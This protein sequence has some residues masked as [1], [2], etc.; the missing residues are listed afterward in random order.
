MK[1]STTKQRL[2]Q[3][4]KE[5]NLRQVDILKRSE[6]YQNEFGVKLSKANLS[7]YLSGKSTPDKKKINLLA[8]TLQVSEAWLSGF[9]APKDIVIDKTD[10]DKAFQSDKIAL[11]IEYTDKKYNHKDRK[12]ILNI[13]E[14]F[15]KL[16]D[17]SKKSLSQYSDI[18]LEATY[19]SDE[20]DIVATI[21]DN[22]MSPKFNE[23]NR[24]MVSF[25][26]DFKFGEI[27]LI[28]YRKDILIRK[29]FFESFK[30]KLIAIN[31]DYPAININ[32]PLDEP[33]K[34]IGKIIGKIN[35]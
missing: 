28:E 24:L 22:S 8:K 27:Y 35:V 17:K 11:D 32:L 16:D 26:Y 29:V 6:Y 9:D 7:Q 3:I 14:N 34:I 13:I 5:R 19:Q 15:D 10:Y 30:I 33:F 18:L 12:K 21:I 4:M 1:V 31:D 2:K 23:G 25:G 20:Y